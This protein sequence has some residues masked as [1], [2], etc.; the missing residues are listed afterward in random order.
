[1]DALSTTLLATAA[2][3]ALVHTAL[4]PDH[5]LPFVMLGKA[6]GWSMRRTMGITAVC[7]LG[8]VLSSMLLGGI[9]IA[10]GVAI[11]KLEWIEAHRGS[12]AAWAL[13]AGGLAYALWGLRHVRRAR[14]GIAMHA[15]GGVVHVHGDGDHAHRHETPRAGPTFWALLLVFILGPCE[16]LIPLFVLPAAEGRWLLAVSTATVFSVVTL[17]T[18][19]AITAAALRGYESLSL[20]RIEPWSHTLAGSVIAASGAAILA[21]GV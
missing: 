10:V 17:G 14:R 13:A 19:L 20:G 7:G 8:H 18:M 3:I 2:G 12:A 4:G 15:H 1:M 9:G 5:Y 21:L 11:G 6:R 16:P